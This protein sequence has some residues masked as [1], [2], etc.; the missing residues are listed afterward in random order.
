MM[1]PEV[2]VIWHIVGWAF[3]SIVALVLETSFFSRL[4]LWGAMPDLM[5]IAVV[6]T[7][8]FRGPLYASSLGFIFGLLEDLFMG[9]LIGVNAL[10]KMLIG[11]LAGMGKGHVFK[12]NPFVP[13]IA[14][15]SM[16]IA[17]ELAIWVL[18]QLAGTAS[19]INS[20]FFLMVVP[21][22]VY[23]SILGLAAYAV[24]YRWVGEK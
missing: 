13:L 7:G 3:F 21:V 9:R 1:S 11:Y 4:Q 15:F 20:G 17:N 5:L 12:E 10:S 18:T 23:N 2:R 22:A 16:T 24:I 6:F 8:L 19:Q 14:V